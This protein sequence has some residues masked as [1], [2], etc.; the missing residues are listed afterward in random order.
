MT[1]T[2]SRRDSIDEEIPYPD[3]SRLLPADELSGLVTSASGDIS[4]DELAMRIADLRLERGIAIPTIDSRWG[5]F[6]D[7]SDREY[8]AWDRQQAE[9][10][11]QTTRRSAELET[12]EYDL[13][14]IVEYEYEATEPQRQKLNESLRVVGRSWHLP[15][16]V[17]A[18]FFGGRI[19]V[20]PS[21]PTSQVL[22]NW[23]SNDSGV[24]LTVTE[25]A[26]RDCDEEQLCYVI[27]H[28]L[29]HGIGE[30]AIM[31]DDAAMQSGEIDRHV[32]SYLR[33]SG[34]HILESPFFMKR[35]KKD[36][37]SGM[38]DADLIE[39]YGA[40][41]YTERLR[42]F[43]ESGGGT[44]ED[45][46]S[47]RYSGDQMEEYLSVKAGIDLNDKEIFYDLVQ[48]KYGINMA[49]SSTPME[50]LQ[51]LGAEGGPLEEL[52]Q[53]AN[54]WYEHFR[55]V[56]PQDRSTWNQWFISKQA[57][58]SAEGN[59]ISFEDDWEM[60]DWEDY[61]NYSYDTGAAAGF[62]S[63]SNKKPLKNIWDSL[64]SLLMP[65]TESESAKR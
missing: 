16:S 44:I 5:I 21:G 64:F 27:A 24:A 31:P 11:L 29:A 9:K 3:L 48:E 36:I 33:H 46:I 47:K 17:M 52:W 40:E 39:K 18:G 43:V 54:Y 1:E 61:S 30:M 37:D 51:R 60:D 2:L 34:A 58:Y 7:E 65:K 23:R 41:I 63:E 49:S 35:I 13:G 26:L 22:G 38:D 14:S 59:I 55:S 25:H 56:M 12:V 50:I 32:L 53:D 20:Q 57:E 4:P 6:S 62:G 10:L 8:R 42:V 45:Y 15:E 28:E 19:L